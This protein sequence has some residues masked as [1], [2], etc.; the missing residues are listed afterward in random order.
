MAKTE[1]W[2]AKAASDAG[3]TLENFAEDIAEMASGGEVSD[4]L[5]NDYGNGDSYHHEN[6]VDKDYDLTEAAELLDQL[7]DYE[8]T[9]SGLWEGL[10][11]RRAIAVQAAH[12]YGNAVY[13]QWEHVIASLNDFLYA[14]ED[15]AAREAAARLWIH[16]E[17][18]WPRVEG[19]EVMVRSALDHLE[20]GD[21][22]CVGALADWYEERG[23]KRAETVRNIVATYLKN[24]EEP[25]DDDDS[26]EAGDAG[27]A[28]ECSGTD[29]PEREEDRA[30]EGAVP[31]PGDRDEGRGGPEPDHEARV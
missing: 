31:E 14:I 12:T 3:D 9:D 25:D 20:N 23:H 15:P 26:A 10:E 19:D 24:R 13:A 30:P 2:L 1:D 16:L 4:D 21:V 7:G 29:Q 6:H 27:S 28:G 11:P 18:G 22:A 8:E 17:Y 5:R